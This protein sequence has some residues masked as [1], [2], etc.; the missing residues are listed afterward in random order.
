MTA[1]L[2]LILCGAL[3]VS[4]VGLAKSDPPKTAHDFAFT[5]IEGHDLPMAGYAGQ[6]VLL[7]N[8]A[9]FCGFTPQFEALQALWSEYR[10]RGLVV[11][12]APSR[13][14][15]A[16]DYADAADARAYCEG[17]YGVDFPMTD[18]VKIRGADAHPLYRWLAAEM[19][20]EG[21]PRGNFHK[22]LI[23]PAGAP[24]AAFPSGV[25][26]DDPVLIAAVERVLPR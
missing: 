14:F 10:D 15:G 20:A 22:V 25:R 7:V 6:A 26:P 9:S 8:T 3:L 19:G 11:L 18:Q 12:A 2:R 1:W 5:A 4:T 24:T 23:D 16:Q 17:A 13:D 21:V